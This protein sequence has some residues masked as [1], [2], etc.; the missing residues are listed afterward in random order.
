MKEI[1]YVDPN[2]GEVQRMRRAREREQVAAA[3]SNMDR[4]QQLSDKR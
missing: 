1:F 3:A 4:E 2:D